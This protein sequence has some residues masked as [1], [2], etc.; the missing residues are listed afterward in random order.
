MSTLS[1]NSTQQ[2]RL[3]NSQN[4]LIFNYYFFWFVCF[5]LWLFIGDS[6][7]NN[8]SVFLLFPEFSAADWWR[9]NKSNFERQIH[10]DWLGVSFKKTAYIDGMV[11]MALFHKVKCG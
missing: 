5:H 6:N 11:N 3:R 1:L 4:S 8:F 9:E 2:L 7:E 10:I